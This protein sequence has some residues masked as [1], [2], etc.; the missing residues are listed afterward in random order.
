MKTN[1]NTED[2][3]NKIEQL[4]E[5]APDEEYEKETNSEDPEEQARARKKL[6]L[7]INMKCKGIDMAVIRG[8]ILPM[9]EKMN[10]A[11]CEELTKIIKKKG[12]YGLPIMLNKKVKHM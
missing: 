4:S 5:I 11:D 12:M 7:M 9:V 6:I 1:T 8:Q 2:I 3:Q 10:I